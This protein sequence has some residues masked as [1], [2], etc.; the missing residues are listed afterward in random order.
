L[1]Q[2]KSNNSDRTDKIKRHYAHRVVPGR[3]HFDILDWAAPETQQQRFE[4]LAD[5]VELQGRSLLDVGCGLGDL[6]SFLDKRG[7]EVEYTGV[8]VVEQMV[9]RAR[10]LHPSRSFECVNIFD[11]PEA[12]GG[13]TFDIVFCSG[14]LNL[15][16][17]NNLEFVKTALP[18]MLCRTKESLVV[19]MLHARMAPGEP[20]YFAYNP[21]T[22]CAILK[23]LCSEVRLIDDYL[24]NDFTVIAKPKM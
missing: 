19:N 7:I 5:N 8:D 24:P 2:D 1:K 6:A 20:Q 14:T 3:A 13:S 11:D 22:I 4:I 10:E 9:I 21:D 12:L 16:L 15:D 17:S 18:A 23:P